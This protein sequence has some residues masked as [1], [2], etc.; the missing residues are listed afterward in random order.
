VDKT[1]DLQDDCWHRTTSKMTRL[2]ANGFCEFK[3]YGIRMWSCTLATKYIFV[4]LDC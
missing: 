1:I 4:I 3:N 2:M